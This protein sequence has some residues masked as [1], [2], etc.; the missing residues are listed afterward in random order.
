MQLLMG[1][2]APS[3]VKY[4]NCKDLRTFLNKLVENHMLNFFLSC[5]L[6]D[7]N[8]LLLMPLC[9]TSYLFFFFY[10]FFFLYMLMLYVDA[11]YL[12]VI[13]LLKL[14]RYLSY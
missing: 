13:I 14:H 4:V 6:I 12:L 11:L 8:S 5:H 10:F 3:L 1:L 2:I 7:I 9:F